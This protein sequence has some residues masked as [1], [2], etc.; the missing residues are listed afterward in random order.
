VPAD[1]PEPG[2]GERLWPGLVVVAALAT[3]LGAVVITDR[4]DPPLAPALPALTQLSTTTVASRSATTQLPTATQL[5]ATAVPETTV[6]RVTT[7]SV[8]K[9]PIGAARDALSAWGRFAVSGDLDRLDGFFHPDGPQ[10]R[11]LAA[12][13]ETLAD[14]PPGPP[15][16]A[17][18]IRRPVMVEWGR[19]RA[20]VRARVTFARRGE[21]PQRNRWDLVMVPGD[22]GDWLLWTVVDQG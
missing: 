5:P 6:A 18:T 2:G 12:E 4:G 10:W 9:T 13:A 16:Y 14:G 22:D 17:V 15:P 1:D 21:T 19:D 20:V 7:T 11:Q 8:V 3:V